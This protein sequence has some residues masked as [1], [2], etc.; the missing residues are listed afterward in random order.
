MH[1]PESWAKAE[2]ECEGPGKRKLK[3][4]VWGWGADDVSAK[5]EAANRLQR[6]LERVRRGEQIPR[7][8]EYGSR[9]LREEI[10]ERF[11]DGSPEQAVA[12]LSRNRYG[13]VV[14][15]T[16]RLLFL[17]IDVPAENLFQRLRRLFSG[18]RRSPAE[19]AL[20]K[21]RDALRGHGRATF[22]LY[23]TAAGLRAIAVD[24]EYD[25]AGP[26][27]QELMKQTGTDPAFMKLCLAQRSFRARL[28]P[29]PWRCSVPLPPEQYPHKDEPTRRRYAEWV[30][31]YETASKGYATCRFLET[32]GTGRPRGQS[33][34]LVE[35]H[36][37]LTRCSE[38]L[39]LA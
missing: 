10:L 9:P 15:N 2:G 22:R 6:L 13:A 36:D 31:R 16:A 27:A 35:L 32:A 33:E 26:D 3:F 29:K 11:G 24:R 5:R 25:P 1:I 7:G 20:A 14:L 38:A 21:L 34:K 28:T 23:R 4:A 12:L 18:D 39:P 30:A 17:D 19:A 8:Y 37:R